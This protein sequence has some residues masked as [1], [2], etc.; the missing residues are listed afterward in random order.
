MPSNE[1]RHYGVPGMRWGRRKASSDSS[2]SSGR[3]PGTRTQAVRR[4]AANTAK[5]SVGL[6]RD[7]R[8]GEKK[9][10]QK[11]VDK[12]KLSGKDKRVVAQ[13]ALGVTLMAAP[14]ILNAL[15]TGM[16]ALGTAA[17]AKNAARGAAAT[18]NLFA[19]SK[20]IA[21]YATVA[22]KQGANGRFS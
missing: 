11:L 2:S 4:V 13:I 12:D 18:R 8:T 1:L 7:P 17:A 9:L 3:A 10:V 21:S 14:H 5:A 20:G 19:D 22:L 15:D 16:G 6:G